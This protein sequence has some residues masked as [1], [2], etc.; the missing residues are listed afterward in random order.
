MSI[1]CRH[2][3]TIDIA[4]CLTDLTSFNLA[5]GSTKTTCI[6][7]R[8]GGGGGWKEQAVSAGS[9]AALSG[10][11]ETSRHR[12]ALLL[13]WKS[14]TSTERMDAARVKHSM[15][16]NFFTPLESDGSSGGSAPGGGKQHYTQ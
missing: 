6:S 11:E 10:G 16:W 9:T 1:I 8:R 3:I 14:H 4:C 2:G 15:V 13:L 7:L 12:R 5:S